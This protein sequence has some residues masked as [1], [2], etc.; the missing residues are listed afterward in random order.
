[1]LSLLQPLR[2][3]PYQPCQAAFR[4]AFLRLLLAAMFNWRCPLPQQINAPLHICPN[5]DYPGPFLNATDSFEGKHIRQA[6]GWLEMRAHS[7]PLP[8]RIP[9]A[10]Q[11]KH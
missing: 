7:N 11:F 9:L 1:M 5:F 3:S 10:L 8:L 4:A 6:Q 2:R